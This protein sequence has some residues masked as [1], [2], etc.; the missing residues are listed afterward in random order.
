MAKKVTEEGSGCRKTHDTR[1]RLR[2][3][4]LASFLTA[5]DRSR[6]RSRCTDIAGDSY[7]F[8]WAS[9]YEN[10]TR[11]GVQGILV[12]GRLGGEEEKYLGKAED[13]RAAIIAQQ[14]PASSRRPPVA[15]AAMARKRPANWGT[16]RRHARA[17]PAPEEAMNRG[18]RAERNAQASRA[19]MKKKERRSPSPQPELRARGIEPG[20]RRAARPEA[21]P[22]FPRSASED[23]SSASRE[24]GA[25]LRTH[26]AVRGAA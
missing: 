2:R 26:E 6:L 16:A 1:H 15:K 13:K 12:E 17:R 19:I 9:G 22:P 8:E 21:A 20:R 23:S 5:L 4:P 18:Y 10:G 24:P 14:A 3:G 7:R 25:R 11:S